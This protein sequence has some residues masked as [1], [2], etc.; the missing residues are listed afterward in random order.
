M[1]VP[2]SRVGYAN[3]EERGDIMTARSAMRDTD[4][5]RTST[6]GIAEPGGAGPRD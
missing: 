2:S 1:G 3:P 4:E 5:P 6:N